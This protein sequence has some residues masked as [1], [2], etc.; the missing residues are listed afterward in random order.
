MREAPSPN[1]DARPAGTAV[2]ILLLHYTGMPSAAAALGRLTDPA[3]KVS[4]HYLVDEDGTVWQLV[5]EARRAWHAGVSCWRG[6]ADVNA[7]SI[8]IELV[9]PGHEHGYRPF[10]EAQMAALQGLALG[11]LARHPIPPGSVLGHA[12]VAPTRRQDPGELFDWRRLA[13]AGIGLWPDSVPP[14]AGVVGPASTAAEIVALQT[15]LAG[16]GYCV[17][18]SGAYDALTRA[19]VTAFQRH[20]RAERIDGLADGDCRARLAWLLDRARRSA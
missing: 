20:W 4:A 11:V 17:A 14:L 5:D 9:N 7:R 8:G 19:A 10:P 1:H 3:A 16:F 12:D 6:V 18:A 13:A 2:D 15:A